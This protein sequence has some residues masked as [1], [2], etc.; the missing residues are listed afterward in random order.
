MRKKKKTKSAFKKT[1][2]KGREKNYQREQAESA[3][4]GGKHLT[5]QA[6]KRKAS[7]SSQI[8]EFKPII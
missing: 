2:R 4:L 5:H 1:N 6:R 8:I 7:Y 3:T